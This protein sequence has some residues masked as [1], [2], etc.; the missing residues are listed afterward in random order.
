MG[1]LRSVGTAAFL[2]VLAS[3]VVISEQATNRQKKKERVTVVYW[4]KWTGDEGDSMQKIV[5][6][7]NESQDRIF[8]QYLSISGVNDKTLL[9]TSGGN[10]PDIAGIWGEQ[11]AQF[12]DAGALMDLTPMAEE[13]GL[14]RSDYIGPY[15][16]MVFYNNKLVALP[17]TPAS[18][19]MHVNRSK[20]PPE[21]DSPEEFPKTIEELD[22]LVDKVSKRSSDDRLILAGF[23]PSE[24]GWWNYGW[25]KLFGG[26]LMEGD[27]LTIDSPENIRAWTWVGQF[28]KKFGNR[29]VQD[30]Q[31]GFGNFSSPQ[32]AFMTGKVATVL[33]GVWMANYIRLYQPKMDWY[34]V[35]FPYPAD[36]PDLK[37]SSFLGLD[38]VVIPRGA[39]HP[40][41][42]FEFLKFVQRQ[43]VMEKLCS[44][45]GKNSPLSKVS[46]NF[47][48]THQNKHIRLF[49]QLART[50]V[51]LFADKLGIWAQLATELN[52]VTQEINLGTKTPEQALHDA[53][54]RLDGQWEVYKKQVLGR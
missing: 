53:Q 13:A 9:A 26:K 31:S 25:G 49:D 27:K 40:K 50:R 18:T 2:V 42:A 47:F 32:N 51:P 45:H 23:L 16:D 10:P 12:A 22:A 34:A 38:I 48:N 29:E 15:W 35:P 36:R 39:K 5:D 33:Q 20:M 4:E 37:G 6:W 19:A 28:G 44:M 11:V 30:F 54:A 21:Y 3:A 8:V 52:N 46:E 1:W 41:E 14:D 17:T 24:P 7:F 43:D